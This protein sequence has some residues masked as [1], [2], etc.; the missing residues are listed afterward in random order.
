MRIIGGA[1]KGK[2]INPPYG[3]PAR[4]TTDYAKEALFNV[5]DNNW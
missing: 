3:Y 5:I 1:L 2:T 4:P